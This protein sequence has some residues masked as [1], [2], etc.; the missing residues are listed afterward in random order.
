MPIFRPLRKLHK[1][2]TEPSEESEFY[3]Q[4]NQM[5]QLFFTCKGMRM[6]SGNSE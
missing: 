3:S 1:I 2:T 4:Y 5:V 6:P